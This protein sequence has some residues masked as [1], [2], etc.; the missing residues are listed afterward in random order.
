M[1]NRIGILTFQDT[2]NYGSWLQ[3]YALYKKVHDLGRDVE[4]IDYKSEELVR[5]EKLTIKKIFLLIKERGIFEFPNIIRQLQKQIQFQQYSKKYLR[6]SPKTYD[7]KTIGESNRKYDIFMIGSDLVWDTR[8]TNMDYTYML[9]FAEEDKRKV[10]YAASLGYE[11]LP[12]KQVEKYKKYLNAFSYITV[13]E[14]Q[15]KDVL[16]GIIH[17]PIEVVAD[18]TL[19]LKKN[20]WLRLVNKRNEN[21]EYVVI[22]FMDE[23]KELLQLAKRYARKHKCKVLYLLG[24]EKDVQCLNPSTIS[25]FLSILYH[26]KKI[27]TASYHGMMFSLYFEKQMVCYYRHPEMRMRF[28]AEKCGIQQVEIHADNFDMEKQIDYKTVK[29]VLDEFRKESIQRLKHMISM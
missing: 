9:D 25:E 21:G 28:I 8:I 15:A 5:R 16:E 23:K 18:P 1:G 2:N 24:K 13:R 11:K 19:L 26:A 3:T 22:Y 29:V 20:E 7:K 4:V 10:S 27:F 14:K 17:V 6:L 12:T